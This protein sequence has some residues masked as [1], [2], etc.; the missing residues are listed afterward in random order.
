MGDK[1][2]QRVRRMREHSVQRRR[3]SEEGALSGGEDRV[4]RE[5]SVQGRRESE[6]EGGLGEGEEGE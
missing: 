3:E 1:G 4:R 6:E 2:G 5:E